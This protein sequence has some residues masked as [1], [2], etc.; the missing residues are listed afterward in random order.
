MLGDFTDLCV[1]FLS[2]GSSG[3]IRE[4]W[5]IWAF[6]IWSVSDQ[7]DSVFR[8]EIDAEFDFLKEHGFR[9]LEPIE[10]S[11]TF[12]GPS[13]AMVITLYPGREAELATTVWSEDR[14]IRANL[15]CLYVKAGLGPPQAIGARPTSEHALTKAVAQVAAAFQALLP[16]LGDPHQRDELLRDCAQPP[17]PRGGPPAYKTTS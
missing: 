2:I 14:S 16:L 17:G 7:L 1:H 8:A 4:R 5:R 12:V 11:Q 9:A 10:H 13:V 15:K 3:F 6:M